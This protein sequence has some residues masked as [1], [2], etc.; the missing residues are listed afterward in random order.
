MMRRLMGWLFG[1]TR[2]VE[3]AGERLRQAEEAENR[4]LDRNR[5]TAIGNT[6]MADDT[7]EAMDALLERIERRRSSHAHPT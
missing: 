6:L 5:R 1:V 7:R 3:E 2:R 4:A